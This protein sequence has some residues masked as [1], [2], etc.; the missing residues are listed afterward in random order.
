MSRFAVAKERIVDDLE[1]LIAELFSA[2]Q[3][4]RRGSLWNVANPYR[5]KSKPEQMAIWLKPPR[6]GAWKDFVSG[7]K[8]DAIDLVAYGLEGHVSDESRIRAVDWIFDRYGLGTL[9]RADRVRIDVEARAR[10]AAADINAVRDLEGRRNRA[11]KMFF[12]GSERLAGTPIDAYLA[13][14]GIDLLA[15]PN[16]T[17]AFRFQPRGEYWLDERRPVFPALLSAMVDG[18]GK[19]GAVHMTLIARDGRGKA[20]VEK[21]KLMWPETSGLV[22]RIANGPSSMTPEQAAE[23]GIKGPCALLEGIEDGMSA[24]LADPGL[25]VWSAGSLSGLGGV[26]DHAAVSAWIVFKDNDWGK[27]QAQA[28]FDRAIRHLKQFNKPVEVVSMPADWGKDVNDA[29]TRQD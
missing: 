6:R 13:G 12:A 28:Q 19:L 9:S 7:D 5:A 24:A 21:P 25:R 11:R 23:A 4:D 3:R 16:L 17:R 15:V 27:R 20:P 18:G 22:I 1:G 10:R 26:P 2:R 8:G 14:R 29:I